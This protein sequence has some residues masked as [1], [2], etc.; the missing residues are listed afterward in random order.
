MSAAVFSMGMTIMFAD[1][2]LP[3]DHIS[4]LMTGPLC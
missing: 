2:E 1:K 4:K 3:I